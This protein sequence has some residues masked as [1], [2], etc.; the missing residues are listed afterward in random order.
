MEVGSCAL[1]GPTEADADA[2]AADATHVGKLWG[3]H[4]V[5]LLAKLTNAVLVKDVRPGVVLPVIY[6]HTAESCACWRR[7]LVK[8]RCAPQ[9]AFRKFHQAHEVVLVLIKW[10]EA[11]V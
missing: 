4:E 1:H 5:S 2:E 8:E 7:P 11:A 6:K 9:F 10:V 3:R